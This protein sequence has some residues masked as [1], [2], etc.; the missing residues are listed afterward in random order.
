MIAA[1]DAV[2]VVDDMDDDYGVAL[3]ALIYAYFA[4]I[5]SLRRLDQAVNAARVQWMVRCLRQSQGMFN[6]AASDA[7][8][9]LHRHE[10]LA[11][12]ALGYRKYDE[13]DKRFQAL[14]KQYRKLYNSIRQAELYPVQDA[15]M[16]MKKKHRKRLL[17]S[18]YPALLG[19]LSTTVMACYEVNPWA[20]FLTGLIVMLSVAFTFEPWRSG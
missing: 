8:A 5:D 18:M 16:L 1:A 13:A 17:W 4:S 2:L 3:V 20:S 12:R 14:V 6:R 11:D 10:E 19:V 7:L 15:N 9:R